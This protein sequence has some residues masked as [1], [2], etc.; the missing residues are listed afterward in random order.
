MERILVD[1]EA[2][3]ALSTSYSGH[4]NVQFNRANLMLKIFKI[5][6]ILLMTITANG[7]TDDDDTIRVKY[8][9]SPDLPDGVSFRSLLAMI[10]HYVEIDREE[11]AIGWMAGELD[12][13]I[14]QASEFVDHAVMTLQNIDTDIKAEIAELACKDGMPVAYNEDAYPVLQ[15]MAGIDISVTEEYLAGLK[16]GFD[17]HTALLLQK[18]VDEHK[19]Y[20][21]YVEIDYAKRAEKSDSSTPPVLSVYCE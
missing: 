16:A 10:N 21:T 4:T 15:Q 8:E 2:S 17:P 1:F 6:V 9:R 3:I 18:W 11:F 13:T 14:D 7:Q 20:T 5:V 12:I 19:L